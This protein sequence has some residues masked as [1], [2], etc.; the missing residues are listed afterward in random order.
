MSQ[1]TPS[2]GN[3]NTYGLPHEEYEYDRLD[4]QH[5]AVRATFG[6]L[7]PRPCREKIVEVLAPSAGQTR[8]ILDLC[9][10]VV[11]FSLGG[12]DVIHGV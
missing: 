10:S 7:Y 9:K 4:V 8:R 6:G 3:N 5:A 11:S 2:H 1:E 12:I